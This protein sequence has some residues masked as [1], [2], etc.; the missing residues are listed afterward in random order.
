L[1]NQ[2][3]GAAKRCGK[4]ERLSFANEQ[5][6]AATTAIESCEELVRRTEQR[7]REASRKEQ[8]TKGDAAA[9]QCVEEI[10]GRKSMGYAN[11]T[12]KNVCSKKVTFDYDD[13][14]QTANLQVSCATKTLSLTGRSTID[15]QNYRQS[16]NVRNIR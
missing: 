2:Y 16:V 6:K 15:I 12:L 1:I 4:S 14:S 9:N 8:G 3:I 11:F 13:C 10:A 5:L 7:K